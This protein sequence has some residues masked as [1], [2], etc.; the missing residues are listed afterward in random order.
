MYKNKIEIC[1]TDNEYKKCLLTLNECFPL[2]KN[3]ENC[4]IIWISQ[5]KFPT[6]TFDSKKTK[7][8]QWQFYV[9]VLYQY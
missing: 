1:Y 8:F 5:K 3:M 4:R 2:K 7:H 6:A 9:A